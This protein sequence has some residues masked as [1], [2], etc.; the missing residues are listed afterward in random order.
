MSAL[1]SV[2]LPPAH[3]LEARRDGKTGWEEV[4]SL[5]E[6]TGQAG[7]NRKGCHS[8]QCSPVACM[9]AFSTF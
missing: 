8:V 9:K 2:L 6:G 1:T 7:K 5:V 4:L 3:N